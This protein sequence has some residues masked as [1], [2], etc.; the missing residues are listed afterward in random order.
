MQLD[1]CHLMIGGKT[2]QLV[3]GNKTVPDSTLGKFYFLFCKEM[4]YTSTSQLM[5]T[6]KVLHMVFV[7]MIGANQM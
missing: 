2:K 7:F 1:L 3:S 4:I 6:S 5:P